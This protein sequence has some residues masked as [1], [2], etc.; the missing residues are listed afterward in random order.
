MLSDLNLYPLS[1]IRYMNLGRALFFHDLITDE[2]IDICSH[3]FHILSKI[4]KR[5][6]LRNCLP[7]CCLILKIL[8]LKGIHPHP[9]QRLIN[10]CTLNAIIVHS[11]KGV[12]QESRA[13]HGGSSS[14]SHPYDE[15]EQWSNAMKSKKSLYIYLSI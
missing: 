11:R 14:S 3:I 13:P 15:G 6:A 5:T 4:A 8:K 7:F 9:M 10:I 2:E 12:K 1:S